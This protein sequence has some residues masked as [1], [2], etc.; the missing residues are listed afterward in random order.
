MRPC[1][2]SW[3]PGRLF[4]KRD[5]N[6][7]SAVLSEGEAKALWHNENPIGAQVKTEGRTFAVI[8]VVAGSRNTSLKSPPAKMAYLHYKDRPPYATVFMVRGMQPADS[9]VASM[10]QAI[11]KYAPDITIARVK[12]LDS[13]LSDSLATERIRF[14]CELRS[15]MLIG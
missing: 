15:G 11:W 1:A 14:C 13:Q 10:R 4:E 6:L 7:N 9:L 5:R 8:G 2:K 12:T 3:L